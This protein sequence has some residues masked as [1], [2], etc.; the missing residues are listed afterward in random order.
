MMSSAP[1]TW[2]RRLAVVGLSLI[3]G[4]VA[5]QSFLVVRFSDA[6]PSAIVAVTDGFGQSL[7]HEERPAESL[8][9]EPD[10]TWWLQIRN[11]VPLERLLHTVVII[12]TNRGDAVV[13]PS[14]RLTHI[15]WNL[16]RIHLAPLTLR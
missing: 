10:G 8:K 9:P 11:S 16:D 7:L 6:Q 15:D 12:S 3:I 13:T 1:S 4:T 14:E 5:A 2:G